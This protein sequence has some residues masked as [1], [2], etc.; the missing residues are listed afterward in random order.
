MLST[1]LSSATAAALAPL[2]ELQQ[3]SGGAAPVGSRGGAPGNFLK[4]GPLNATESIR[5]TN[6]G[7]KPTKF[8]IDFVAKQL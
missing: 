2:R 3:G 5:N 7:Q 6:L 8:Q 1:R 4:K